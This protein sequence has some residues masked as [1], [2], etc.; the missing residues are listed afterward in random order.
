M[1]FLSLFFWIQT[2][3]AQSY[4]IPLGSSKTSSSIIENNHQYSRFHFT[5]QALNAIEVSTDHGVFTELILPK[6][7]SIGDIG[8]PKLPATKNLIEIPLG[9]QVEVKV[10]NYSVTEI[11]LSDLGIMYPL[12][13]L[14]PSSLKNPDALLIPFQLQQVYYD[15]SAYTVN[16]IAELEILGVLRGTRLAR[17]TVAPVAY[18]PQQNTIQVYN[19]IEVELRYTGA[20]TGL[21]SY[22]KASTYSPYFDVVYNQLLNPSEREATLKSYPDL[23]RTPVKMLVISHIDFKET[24]QPFIEWQTRKGYKVIAAYTNEIGN[25][26]EAIKN[27][28]RNSYQQSH[29]GDPAPTFL[30]LVGDVSKLPASGIGSASKEVTDLYYASVDGDVFPDMYYGRL[31]ARNNSELKNIIDKILYY[32]QYQFEDPSYLDEVTLIAGE[33]SFWNHQ[34]LQPTVKYATQNYYNNL[35]GFS[36]INSFLTNYTGSYSPRNVSVGYINFTGHCKPTEWYNPTLRTSNIYQMNN[37]G[38][39]PLVIGNCCQ[40]GLFSHSESIGEA[41]V[42]AK[43][44]GAVA[45]IGS[46][47][48]THWF[49]DF[50]WSVGAFPIVGNNAGYVPTTAETTLGAYD[51]PFEAD[52]VPVG[53]IQFIGNLSITQANIRGYQ[54]HSNM[55]WYWEGYHTFGDPST[56]IYH[57]QGK[58]NNV[59]HF[60]VIPFGTETFEVEALP[61][62]YVGLSKEGRLI[63]AGKVDGSGKLAL[64]IHTITS[65]GFASLVVTKP[66]YVPYIKEI[67]VASLEG[68]YIVLD[69]VDI[70]DETGNNNQRADYGESISLHMTMKNIGSGASGPLT[71]QFTGGDEFVTISNPGNQIAIPSLHATEGNNTVTVPDAFY[72][73]VSEQVPNEHIAFFQLEVTDGLVR[74]RSNLRITAYAPKLQIYHEFVINDSQAGNGNGRL[75]QGETAAV[76]FRIT[77]KGGATANNPTALLQTSSPYL[78]VLNGQFQGAAIDPGNSVYSTFQVRASYHA[79]NG[80]K[81]PII[82]NVEDGMSTVLDT[83]FT[84]GFSPDITIG[85]ENIPSGQYPFYNIYKANRSQLLYTSEELGPGSKKITSIAFDFVQISSQFNA[86]PNFKILIVHTSMDQFNNE[87]ADMTDAK[88]VFSSPLYQMPLSTGRHTWAIDHFEYD[89]ERNIIIEI[90]WGSLPGWTTNFFKVECSAYSFNRVAYGYSDLNPIASYNGMSYIRPNISLSFTAD[91]IPIPWPVTFRVDDGSGNALKNIIIQIGELSLATDENGEAIFELL[92][93]NYSYSARENGSQPFAEQSF[94]VSEEAK[95]IQLQLIKYYDAAFFVKNNANEDITDATISLNGTKHEPGN[96]LISSLRAGIYNYVVS[97]ASFFD[98]YGSF[99]I[100]DGDIDIHVIMLPDYTGITHFENTTDFKVF[101]VPARDHLNVEIPTLNQ[102]ATI[103]LH[104]AQ[105]HQVQTKVV[106]AYEN[107]AYLEFN[108][109]GLAPGLYYVKLTQ[110]DNISFQKVIIH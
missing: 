41:W 49:E 39:Y 59:N 21:E 33:D 67:N 105:G 107:M 54:T 63:A 109:K 95:I 25:T 20:D 73:E 71:A 19:D 99:N 66:Q 87:F 31:S 23:S 78:D 1:L 101:P 84:I 47:P 7:H 100:N 88:V 74:W 27:F 108:L 22:V 103:S 83:V 40:S 13:P 80:T 77:N 16:E 61:G 42:R 86:L 18:N 5:F 92:P 4:H 57:T 32:Q 50:Y 2:V 45:Y 68:P 93:G 34:I 90:V 44:R 81:A 72:I 53:A 48:D 70:N 36:R 79:P 76:T 35:N 28:I 56:I 64:P 6:G 65:Q 51:A 58:I 106:Q 8:A 26:P 43:D 11:S 82:L 30:V 91:P 89:G 55:T 3:Y 60:P 37:T 9:A 98:Y 14:Q 75:D 52:Y 46:A 97:R 69:H 104:N 15:K 96:Y 85:N 12:M 24:L 102:N 29:P 110:G 38:K 94:T 62:S 17:L 10:I